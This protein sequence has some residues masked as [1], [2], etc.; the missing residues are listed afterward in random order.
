M[1]LGK[2]LTNAFKA[3]RTNSLTEGAFLARDFRKYGNK[4]IAQDWAA[5]IISDQDMYTGY[6][7][8]AINNRAN[9]VAQLAT[10]NL[11]TTAKPEVVKRA[12]EKDEVL[13]H[14][15]IDI[16]DKSKTF[17]NY[18]FWYEI[19]TFIDLE[20]VYYLM[21]IR[22]VNGSRVGNIVEFK[23]LNPYEIKRVINQQTREL[24]GYVEGRD[25]MTREIPKEMI[26]EIRRLNPFSRDDTFSM[27]DAA[28]DSQF[29][30]KQ[31]SDHT[32]SSIQKNIS[33]PGIL[34]VDDQDLALDAVKFENF[35][36]R[37]LGKVR[38]EPIFGVGKGSITW[39]DMQIDLDKAAL[40]KVNEVN[41]NALIAVTGNSKTMFGI[42][43]S[44]VTRDTASIQQELF[45]SNHTM[46][47]LQLIVDALNQDY[48]NYYEEEYLSQEMTIFIESPLGE[49]K[50]VEIKENQIRKER[51]E[52]LEALIAAGY[53]PSQASQYVEGKMELSELSP[54]EKPEP[55]V[56]PEPVVEEE[57]AD[58]HIHAI[59]NLFEDESGIVTQQQGV[60]E[61]AVRNIEEQTALAVM[62]KVTKNDYDSESD[63]ITASERKRIE[64]ELTT[65]LAAF[66]LVIIPLYA[67]RTMNR[68]SKE[69]T[70]AG[71][72]QVNAEVKRYVKQIASKSAASHIDT[73]LDDLLRAVRETA[74]EGAS[75]QELINAIRSKYNEITSNRAKA[76]ARTETNR[77]F[78]QSQFQADKQFIKQNKLEGRAYKKWITRSS[79]PCPL[80]LEMASR[81]PVP[82]NQDFLDFGD[83]LTVTYEDD[84]KTR[85]VKQKID[86]EPLEAGNLHTNCACKYQLI[87]E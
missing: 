38:G 4:R 69:F 85:V 59:S 84:G 78:T 86:Y 87:I 11:T 19:S 25:G 5:T 26:I 6:S 49:D 21:A 52:M 68:R 50:E 79:N 72:F 16:I 58:N 45:I 13:T 60:L 47:Q 57:E 35:K 74:L 36:S 10:N 24:G 77:A 70:M 55:P 83:T 43:Q 61:T 14:K 41:L 81:P 82:F 34:T 27:S 40:D 73:I 20:G 33:S 48:K 54:P 51:F 64:S 23:L 63:I 32:R 12:K 22:N 15:Y 8:A 62:S 75:Q 29:T 76:I 46:P 3:F 44:G 18:Q 71:I 7:F 53:D 42:E 17:S 65:A 56:I 37:I 2:K 39:D 67:R 66:Y 30:L 28:K 9:G 1:N 80:C 31:A